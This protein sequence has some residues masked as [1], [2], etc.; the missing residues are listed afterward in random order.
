[1]RLHRSGACSLGGLCTNVVYPDGKAVSY[2]YDLD[3][4]V[5][6]V[7]DWANHAWTFTRDAAGRLGTM[8][9]PNGVSGS[10]TH[11]GNH[12]VSGWSYNNGSPLAGRTITRDE[13][14]I[15]TEEQV[16]VG[17]FPN[18]TSPRRAA[19]TFDAADRLT[20]AT[21][22]VGTNTFAE[23][24]LYDGNGALTNRLSAA[25]DQQFEYDCAGRL[26]YG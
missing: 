14:G 15:K 25:G 13:A 5:T 3:G 9:C 21:L 17:L 10:W 2:A 20:S 19:N 11:D 24:Y 22:A 1:L 23:T 16:T 26:T 6:N 12:R 7:T 8:T 4:H 18:P